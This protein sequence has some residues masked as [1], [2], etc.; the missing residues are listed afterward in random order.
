MATAQERVSIGGFIEYFREHL[1]LSIPCEQ[2]GDI[3]ALWIIAAREPQ[4]CLYL[5]S[6]GLET[7]F[8]EDVV[9]PS[10]DTLGKVMTGEW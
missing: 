10:R 1:E 4:T 8:P 5:L 7:L 6:N 3:S 2:D 9:L